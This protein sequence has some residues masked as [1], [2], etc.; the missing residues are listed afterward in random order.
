MPKV[1]LNLLETF[2]KVRNENV[3]HMKCSWCGKH[4]GQKTGKSTPHSRKIAATGKPIITYGICE[5]C[6]VEVKMEYT[7]IAAK[8]KAEGRSEVVLPRHKLAAITT[9]KEV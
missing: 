2:E 3:F 7:K 5:E 6:R 4:M 1:N 9:R 8:K